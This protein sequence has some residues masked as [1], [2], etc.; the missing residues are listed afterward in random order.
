MIHFLAALPIAIL[1]A[2]YGPANATEPQSLELRQLTDAANSIG[3]TVNFVDNRSGECKSPLL[4]GVYVF[5]QRSVHLCEANAQSDAGFLKTYRHELWHAA[6][7]VC[8]SMAATLTD[9]QI[10]A[11]LPHADR[12]T[13][14][15]AY[16]EHQ[17]RAE[18]EARVV[19]QLPT[20]DY[21]RGFNKV[22]SHV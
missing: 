17:F 13:L 18:A 6:Q 5:S 19:A 4:L 3:V 22:C 12:Q 1:S 9:D 7:H 8:R 16:P 11:A 14:R 2:V 10:R 15:Q 20:T 21:L